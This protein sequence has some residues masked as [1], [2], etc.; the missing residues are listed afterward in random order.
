MIVLIIATNL[1]VW[2]K[3]VVL[4]SKEEIEQEEEEDSHTHERVDLGRR[5]PSYGTGKL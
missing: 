4:E 2:V 1:C 3:T 5:R